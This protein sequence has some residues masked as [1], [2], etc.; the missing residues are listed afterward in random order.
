MLGNRTLAIL[1]PDCVEKKL[2]G[3]VVQKINEAGFKIL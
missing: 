2:I 1:K 3:Q